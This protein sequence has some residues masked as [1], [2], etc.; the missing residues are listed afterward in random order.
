MLSATRD[1]THT[2]VSLVCLQKGQ[3]PPGVYM[4]AANIIVFAARRAQHE[5]QCCGSGSVEVGSGAEGSR[6]QVDTRTG[7]GM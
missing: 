3:H 2:R 1:T 5:R 4:P 7:K 6:A